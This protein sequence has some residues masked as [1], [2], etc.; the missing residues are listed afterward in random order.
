MMVIISI[1]S[2]TVISCGW[3]WIVVVTWSS[4]MLRKAEYLAMDLL[5]IRK[6]MSVKAKERVTMAHVL[7]SQ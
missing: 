1:D 3:G 7:Y 5:S 2:G 4:C 6:E